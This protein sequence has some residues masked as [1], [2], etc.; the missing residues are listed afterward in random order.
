MESHNRLAL[1]ECI[2]AKEMVLPFLNVTFSQV[3]LADA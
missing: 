1:R 3:V 2:E